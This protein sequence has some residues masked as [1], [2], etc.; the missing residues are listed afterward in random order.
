MI[1]GQS[2]AGDIPMAETESLIG[3]RVLILFPHMVM[4][5]GALN[6][7]LKLANQLS[8]RGATVGILTMKVDPGRFPVPPGVDVI[9][10]EGPLTSSL[11]YWALLPFWQLRLNRA[12]AAWMPDLLI[13]QVF[14]SNWW[15]WLYKRK[16]PEVKLAWVCQE[17]SA[18]IHSHAWIMALKPWWKSRMAMTLRPLLAALDIHLARFSDR[19]IANSRF[20]A[21]EVERVYRIQ[22]DA[23]ACPGIEF[24]ATRDGDVRKER[25][26][27]TVARLTKFK[28][29]DFLLEVFAEVLKSHPELTY[30][31]VGTGEDAAPLQER[32]LYLGIASRV[33]FHGSVDGQTLDGLYRSSCLFLH[34]SVNEPFG[35]APLEAISWGTPVVAHKS[36]G[37]TEF[38]TDRCGR[39]I[40]SL[41]VGTWAEEIGAYLGFLSTHPE[42]SEQVRDAARSFDWR[43]SLRPA[44]EVIAGLGE[45]T[46]VITGCLSA[47]HPVPER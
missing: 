2:S 39:L 9:S 1:S 8:D 20:T 11:R 14:P 32:A 28:R 47:K 36:G 21:T 25:S 31:I 43:I 24:P 37:L 26:L 33:I 4:S 12:I 41:E 35:M 34:G 19:V 38:V 15:G 5:G 7:M 42:V 3:T 23:I 18:F 45:E 29:I 6:Y 44:V 40:N 17:P 16:H 46:G 10:L 22:A 13:P 30:H 27:I